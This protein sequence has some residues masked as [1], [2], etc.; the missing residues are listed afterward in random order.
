MALLQW[1]WVHRV[2]RPGPT[3]W[4]GPYGLFGPRP[5]TGELFSPSMPAACRQN[6]AGRRLMVGGGVDGEEVSDWWRQRGGLTKRLV[7]GGGDQRQGKDVGKPEQGS[8]AGSKQL[9]RKYSTVRCL[10]RGRGGRRGA[11][12]VYPRWLSDDEHDGAVAVKRAEEEGNG[13]CS[14]VGCSFY[15][16]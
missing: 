16:R 10:G 4:L 6:P 3:K 11:G 7:H 5:K 13:G 14:T 1:A 15:R 9:G 2:I 12:A 8:P